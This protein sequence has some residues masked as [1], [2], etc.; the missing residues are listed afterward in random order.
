LIVY[1]IP[2]PES[3]ENIVNEIS[4]G[5]GSICIAWICLPLAYG[6]IEVLPLFS[7]SGTHPSGN[8]SHKV[9]LFFNAAKKSTEYREGNRQASGTAPN[10][11]HDESVTSLAVLNAD[12]N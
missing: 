10:V 7:V 9:E 4:Q 6:F 12:I 2:D 11:S 5:V 1:E 3:A 8:A